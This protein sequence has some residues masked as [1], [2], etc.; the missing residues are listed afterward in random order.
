MH[1]LGCATQGISRYLYYE[2]TPVQVKNEIVVAK[3][4]TQVWDIMVKEIAKSF[5]VINNI[6]KESRIINMSFSTNLPSVFV[7]CGKSHRTYTQ[8]DKTEVYDYDIAGPAIYKVATGRQ[9][10]EFLSYYAVVS[11]EALLEGRSNIYI[12]PS[13]KDNSSSTV[14]VNT[15]FI[16]TIKEKGGTFAENVNGGVFSL[17]LLPEQTTVF[18]CDTNHPGKH[19]IYVV[20]KIT[21]TCFSKGKL[22][23]DILNMV[24]K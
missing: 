19:D 2:N 11:R 22:E 20:E 6:D 10:N 1:A 18:T 7:D 5:F 23:N 21:V 8:G 9:E 16:L 24:N 14:T 12:A 15:R 4:Y 17:G 3:P 13:E